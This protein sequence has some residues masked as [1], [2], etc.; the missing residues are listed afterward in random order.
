MEAEDSEKEID[1]IDEED[2]RSL[3]IFSTYIQ[4]VTFSDDYRAQTLKICDQ[5]QAVPFQEQFSNSVCRF[6]SG[7]YA[8]VYKGSFKGCNEVIVLK[9]IRTVSKL[10]QNRLLHISFSGTETYEDV[11][12]ELVISKALSR[13]HETDSNTA[14]CFPKIL[15]AKLVKG[16]IPTHFIDNREKG[17][18]QSP[19][20]EPF[21]KYHGAP[22][23]YVVIAM[24]YCGEPMWKT[25]KENKINGYALLSV[26]KQVTFGL[27]VAEK[28][29]MF[30]HRDLHISNVLIKP[31]SKPYTVFIFE[32]QEYHVQTCGVRA[33]II[34]TT[35]SRITIDNFVY[36]KDMSEI[37]RNRPA[38][39][40]KITLQSEVYQKMV[41]ET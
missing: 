34:D 12:N 13:L 10:L 9:V 4:K 3:S 28:R 17:K 5:N 7:T 23:E 41:E 29:Y 8:E 27:A 21:S 33:F 2:L 11:Y 24:K 18:K 39:N 19:D 16:S 22:V 35:F 6:D 38:S 32:D 37:L 14:H 31:T 1:T 30:E 36:Y 15:D 25:I 40:E 26:A 20:R